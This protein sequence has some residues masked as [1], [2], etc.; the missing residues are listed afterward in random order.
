MT[1]HWKKLTNPDYLGAYAFQRGEEKLVTIDRVRQELVTGPEGKKSECIVAHFKQPGIKPMILNHTNAK[2][3]ERLCGT[4][5]IEEW[6]GKS[7][8]LIVSKVQAF[9]EQVDAV[10]VKLEKVA[11]VCCQCGH[12]VTAAGGMSAQQVAE[13]TAG[14][15]GQVLCAACAKQLTKK[16]AGGGEA[17]T[18][19]SLA[20]PHNIPEPEGEKVL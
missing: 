4:P 8:V 3:I 1:T 19:Q 15:F 14:K 9:G 16:P 13:Y 18:L 2:T 5:Y 11:G 20:T 12:R 17:D 10:R 6:A 7:V